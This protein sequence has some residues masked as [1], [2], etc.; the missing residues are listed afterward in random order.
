VAADDDEEEARRL[1]E[2]KDAVRNFGSLKK[3]VF[4]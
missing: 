3:N 4:F 2:E 1:Q